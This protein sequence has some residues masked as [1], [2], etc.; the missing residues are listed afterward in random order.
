MIRKRSCLDSSIAPKF[1]QLGSALGHSQS[2]NLYLIYDFSQSYTC[3]TAPLRRRLMRR[4]Y[5]S[6]NILKTTVLHFWLQ[7]YRF[8]KLRVSHL[9]NLF[10]FKSNS[11]CY[12][13]V[14]FTKFNATQ[15]KFTEVFKLT[16]LPLK[17]LMWGKTNSLALKPHD[18][19]FLSYF[20][21]VSFQN[22][23]PMVV[24]ALP[25]KSYLTPS[26]KLDKSLILTQV[27]NLTSF[28]NL[29]TLTKMYYQLFSLTTL[30][31]L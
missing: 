5:Y 16:A 29:I 13:F 31:K 24:R 4:K 10:F 21:K 20:E 18:S 11:A 23:V 1:K 3:T 30:G 22:N 19:L 17:V 14:K 25:N 6:G 2:V 26:Y 12:N 15:D 8:Y 27:L 7:E 28:I 9:T